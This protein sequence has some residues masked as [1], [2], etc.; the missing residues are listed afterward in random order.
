MECHFPFVGKV[1][2]FW[3]SAKVP[4]E[5][6]EIERNR[7]EEFVF[8]VN[9]S[10]EMPLGATWAFPKLDVIVRMMGKEEAKLP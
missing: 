8:K 1:V 3:S 5:L 7:F 6:V 2:T 9:G 4:G 10:V